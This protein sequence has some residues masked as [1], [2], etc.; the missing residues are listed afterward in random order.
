MQ[1]GLSGSIAVVAIIAFAGYSVYTSL[2]KEVK[3]SKLLL[4]NIVT[5]HKVKM[6]EAK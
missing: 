5:S 2:N 4:A 3:L 6:V 1:K